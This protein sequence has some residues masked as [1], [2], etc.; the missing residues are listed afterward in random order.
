MVMTIEDLADLPEVPRGVPIDLGSSPVRS[1]LTP[2]IPETTVGGIPVAEA[3]DTEATRATKEACLNRT[4]SKLTQE[5]L[6][7]A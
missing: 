4:M 3:D 7:A 5:G 1:N 6:D 2:P